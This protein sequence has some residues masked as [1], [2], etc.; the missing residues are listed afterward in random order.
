MDSARIDVSSESILATCPVCAW[1]EI[2]TE[3]V[4]LR[5]GLLRHLTADHMVQPE[6]T[7]HRETQRR[8][9]RRRGMMPA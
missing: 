3:E 1:R 7:Q 4:A 9:F 2:G 6:A 5:R 8:W